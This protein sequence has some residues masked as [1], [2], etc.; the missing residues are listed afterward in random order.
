MRRRHVPVVGLLAALAALAVLASVL[1][2][3]TLPR[4]VSWQRL[5]D[6]GQAFGAVSAVVSAIAL[7]GIVTSLVI[8]QKQNR[9]ME[10]QT[11]RQ[12][13]FELV[14][15]TMD[16][17]K[18]LDVWGARPDVDYDPALLGFATL[19]VSHWLML[20]RIGNIDEEALR[21]NATAYF[22]G[23]IG[24]D[25]W[26]RSGPGWSTPD[27]QAERFVAIMDEEYR[28]ALS[29][30]PPLGIPPPLG[31]ERESPRNDWPLIAGLALAVAAAA[32]ARQIKRHAPSPRP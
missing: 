14:R 10:E 29:A 18:F 6:V 28:R 27:R 30:G 17:P 23:G 22:A 32:A 2:L 1:T 26:R 7:V 16:D 19:V 15:L 9:V 4:R 12:R 25:H 31:R 3:V 24:R 5:S 20:W 8:Q 11:V 21:R 13:H